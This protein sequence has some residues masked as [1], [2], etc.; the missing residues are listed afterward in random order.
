MIAIPT[1]IEFNLT[2][3]RNGERMTERRESFCLSMARGLHGG[4]KTRGWILTKRLLLALLCCFAF[5]LSS[6]TL[7]AELLVYIS[8]GIKELTIVD[9][10]D[11][12]DLDPT[13]SFMDID[14][15]AVEEQF[16]G[17]WDFSSIFGVYSNLQD[18]DG[19]INQVLNI[20]FNATNKSGASANLTFLATFR[21]NNGIEQPTTF[22]FSGGNRTDQGSGLDYTFVGSYRQDH[23]DD[24]YTNGFANEDGPNNF[25]QVASPSFDP[26]DTQDPP[27]EFTINMGS[28]EPKSIDGSV[29][30]SIT[31]GVRI[32]NL[33]PN[34][35]F[36]GSSELD[37]LLPEPASVVLWS[38][39]GAS[40]FYWRRKGKS[41][42]G[43][44]P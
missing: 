1:E 13:N 11:P 10:E 2:N 12:Y 17:R 37:Y 32:T 9:N 31:Y 43:E 30:Y 8:D 44:A 26:F 28:V 15:R 4:I 42:R 35:F 33:S 3:W 23:A 16:N 29:T 21:G 20:N 14:H 34:K 6:A 19:R 27:N 5:G 39:V 40:C 18:I 36:E 25:V 41:T 7:K 22:S 24:F 38:A